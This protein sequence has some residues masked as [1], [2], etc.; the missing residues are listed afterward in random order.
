MQ[1]IENKTPNEPF[2]FRTESTW[3]LRGELPAAQYEYGS[4]AAGGWRMNP[5]GHSVGAEEAQQLQGHGCLFL[6]HTCSWEK[7]MGREGRKQREEIVEGIISRGTILTPHVRLGSKAGVK[8][9]L[10]C[11][12]VILRTQRILSCAGTTV[13]WFSTSQYRQ[14]K[15][16]LKKL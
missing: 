3:G 4:A 12:A 13:L 15:I 16:N 7:K 5:E 1:S 8:S 10:T 14:V 2:L 6:L 9:C 11:P